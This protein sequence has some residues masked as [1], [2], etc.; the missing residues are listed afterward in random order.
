MQLRKT[1]A[2]EEEKSLSLWNAADQAGLLF[3]SFFYHRRWAAI[4]GSI[5]HPMLTYNFRDCAEKLRLTRNP[6]SRSR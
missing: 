4:S 5:A 1:Q 3:F 6:P 2:E